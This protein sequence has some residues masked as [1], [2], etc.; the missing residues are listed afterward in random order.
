MAFLRDQLEERKGKYKSKCN[1]N[2]L[3]KVSDT[4]SENSLSSLNTNKSSSTDSEFEIE[5]HID[6]TNST[7]GYLA[8]YCSHSSWRE[9]NSTST[10][11]NS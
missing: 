3:D 11:S 8:P 1:Y 9:F 2:K 4:D 7:K 6:P 5:T 10:Y